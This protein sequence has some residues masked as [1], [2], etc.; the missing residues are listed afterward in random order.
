MNNPILTE[1]LHA[2]GYLIGKANLELKCDRL[3]QRG[4]GRGEMEE[5]E[6]GEEGGGE[7]RMMVIM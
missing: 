4:E 1:V 2:T 3:E 6:E 5:G 7:E